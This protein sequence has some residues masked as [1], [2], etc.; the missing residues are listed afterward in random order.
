MP[1]LGLVGNQ[2]EDAA[3][4]GG[5]YRGR[6]GG[7]RKPRACFLKWHLLTS[8]GGNAAALEMQFKARRVT[9]RHILS[10]PSPSLQVPTVPQ[11]HRKLDSKGARRNVIS[12]AKKIV[13]GHAFV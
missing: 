4:R 7:S 13:K 11:F 8:L 1:V 3:T 12:L 6:E 9:D 2:E 5:R 10:P